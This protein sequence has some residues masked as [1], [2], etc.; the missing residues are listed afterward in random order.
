MVRCCSCSVPL[1]TDLSQPKITSLANS[2]ATVIS[3]PDLYRLLTFQVPNLMF[4][5]RC[6]GR[7]KI[8]VQVRGK[9]LSFV[10]KPVFTVR[11]CQHLAQ[12]PSW[13]TKPCRLSAA[14]YSIYS[15]L[16]SIMQVAPSTATWGHDMPW[17]Q[18]PT[19]CGSCLRANRKTLQLTLKCCQ[20]RFYIGKFLIAVSSSS[21]LLEQPHCISPE[22][23][24]WPV[25]SP[26]SKSLLNQNHKHLLTVTVSKPWYDCSLSKARTYYPHRIYYRLQ[27]QS[28]I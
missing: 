11:S 14:A 4:L 10:T 3:E 6:L 25:A 27:G 20:N 8:S 16:P 19:Y 15:H 7:T 17:W 23:I 28:F 26:I 13:R 5:F 18:G 1:I 12:P 21:P 24:Q 2:L 22:V 9:C